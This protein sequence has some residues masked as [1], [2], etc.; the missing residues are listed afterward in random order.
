MTNKEKAQALV[1]IVDD[2]ARS[3]AERRAAWNELNDL[4]RKAKASFE[5][6]GVT[7]DWRQAAAAKLLGAEDPIKDYG[8]DLTKSMPIVPPAD[9]PTAEEQAMMAEA[10]ADAKLDPL[11]EQ[12]HAIADMPFQI[13]ADPIDAVEAP[14]AAA[15]KSPDRGRITAMIRDRLEHGSD[16]YAVIADD[17]RKAFPDARTTARSIASIAADLRKAGRDIPKRE[18]K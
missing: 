18:T 9:T 2:E 12:A 5:K 4:K 15:G 10:V 13:A 16:P 14:K 1:A 17:V 3:L 7:D 6:L 8:Q 11:D